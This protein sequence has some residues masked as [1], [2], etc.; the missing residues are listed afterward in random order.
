MHEKTHTVIQGAVGA[1]FPVAVSVLS[2][3]QYAEAWLRMLSL[4]I[5]CA[6]GIATIISVTKKKP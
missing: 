4:L 5:G 6:V 1:A 3:L 2:W